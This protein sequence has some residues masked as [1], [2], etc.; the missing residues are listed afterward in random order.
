MDVSSGSLSALRAKRQKAAPA[1]APEEDVSEAEEEI[2]IRS[3]S[4]RTVTPEPPATSDVQVIA[5]PSSSTPPT[6]HS[7]PKSQH[8]PKDVDDDIVPSTERESGIA[9][10][11]AQEDE[12]ANA[13]M[14]DPISSSPTV[15]DTQPRDDDLVDPTTQR[16]PSPAKRRPKAKPKPLDTAALQSMLPKRRKQ[17]LQPRRR[18]TEYEFDSD[19]PEVE[20]LE[21]GHLEDD[22]DELGGRL[23]AQ[24][25]TARKPR[26][27]TKK[28]RPSKTAPTKK[29][30]AAA[31]GAKEKTVTTYSRGANASDKENGGDESFEEAD[32]STLPEI[33]VS[34]QELAQSKELEE[35]KRKFADIDQWDMEFETMSAE[36]HRSSSQNWR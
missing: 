18:K 14:A 24:S 11:P 35:V 31:K 12:D 34:M 8:D 28:G 27:T 10:A 17:P 4:H 3:S 30:S 7:S 2:I 5:S 26:A 21:T 33:S 36:D 13:T 9:D 23:R 32:E 19:P 25:K 22:E 20:T 1:A 29:T 16:S 6:E 15:R